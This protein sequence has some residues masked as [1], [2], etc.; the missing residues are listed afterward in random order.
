MEISGWYCTD[1]LQ[2]RWELTGLCYVCVHALYCG[3]RVLYRNIK[4]IPSFY[5]AIAV[6]V[7]CSASHEEN[8]S[9]PNPT[10]KL[11]LIKNRMVSLHQPSK[12]GT[13]SPLP[14]IL[15]VSPSESRGKIDAGSHKHLSAESCD[16]MFLTGTRAM[17]Q[18]GQ[19]KLK[20]IPYFCIKQNQKS[21]NPKHSKQTKPQRTP[22]NPLQKKLTA[23]LLN[24]ETKN[25]KQILKPQ[26]SR[27]REKK[28]KGKKKKIISISTLTSTRFGVGS[29]WNRSSLVELLSYYYRTNYPFWY[30]INLFSKWNFIFKALWKPSEWWGFL[31]CVPCLLS[32]QWTLLRMP[33]FLFIPS[34][35]SVCAL[36]KSPWLYS[37]TDWTVPVVPAS[38]LMKDAPVPQLSLWTC[39]ALVPVG[40]CVSFIK[41]PGA[42]HSPP[43]V[44]SAVLNREEGSPL[45]IYGQCS[46]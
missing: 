3:S 18:K 25:P 33:S 35:Q 9:S 32:C 6:V 46:S 16:T 44:V 38:P 37:S 17:T 36:I 27:K 20:G 30:W 28:E 10:Q 19:C 21:P 7:S 13:T 45:L 12:P 26:H 43:A 8:S 39:A 11:S 34:H 1:A 31:T 41:E 24:K 22:H 40:L 2:P 4:H 5:F 14:Y 23:C 42:E 29:S 15:L